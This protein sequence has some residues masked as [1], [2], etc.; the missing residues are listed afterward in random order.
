MSGEKCC[1]IRNFYFLIEVSDF[2]HSR[3][4]TNVFKTCRIPGLRK[5][6]LFHVLLLYYPLLTVVS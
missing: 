6:T 2:I 4:I 3:L 5:G 1:L